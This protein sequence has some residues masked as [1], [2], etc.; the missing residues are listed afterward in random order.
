LDAAE[1]RDEM[2]RK[3]RQKPL[4]LAPLSI[5]QALAGAIAVPLPPIRKIKK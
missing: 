1:L 3:N 4:S 2:D 5:E